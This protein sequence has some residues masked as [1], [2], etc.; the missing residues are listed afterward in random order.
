[1]TLR[2]HCKKLNL[3]MLLPFPRKKR[4]TE[5]SKAASISREKQKKRFESRDGRTVTES[6]IKK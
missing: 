3:A 6:E 1:M 4:Q 5:R 2:I